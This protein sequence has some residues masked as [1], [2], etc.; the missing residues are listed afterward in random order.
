MISKYILIDLT[1]VARY[2][3]SILRILIVSKDENKIFSQL[4]IKGVK[5]RA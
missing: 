5:Q 2:N 4:T 3:E 1:L